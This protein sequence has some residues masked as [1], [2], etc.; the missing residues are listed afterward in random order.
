[1]PPT[2]AASSLPIRPT[3]ENIP[4]TKQKRDDL[5]H[6]VRDY[7]RPEKLVAPLTLDELKFHAAKIIA[8][9]AAD[10][11]YIDFAVILLNNEL[12]RPVVK[13][14]PYDKRLL[15]LPKC[16]RN[17]ITC[18][19]DLDEMGLI[20]RHCGQCVIDELKRYAEQLGYA[21]LIAEGSP[22]VLSLIQ[23]G[24]VQAIIG[25]SCTAVL[26]QT[27]PFMLSAAIPAVAIP[28][29]YD[30][31]RN[32][33][34][35]FD[36]LWDAVSMTSKTANAWLN[37]EELRKTVASWFTQTNLKKILGDLPSQAASLA[38]E[39]LA[40]A[41]KRYRPLLST[42]AYQALS[43]RHGHDAVK[44][45]MPVAVAVEC[46]HKASL[47]HDDIEDSDTLRYGQKTLHTEFGVPIALNVGDYLIGCGYHL[48]T[49]PDIP[50]QHKIKMLEIAAAAHLELCTGQGSELA[51][52]RNPEPL[53]VSEVLEILERKTS[54][55]FEAALT[56]AAVFAD[57]PE[58]LYAVLKQYSRA[59]GIA[60]Q[61]QD[62]I[63]DFASEVDADLMALR[64]SVL[65]ALAF[66][67]AGKDNKKFL[68]DCC[69]AVVSQQAAA[70]IRSIIMET[71]IEQAAWQLVHSYK[72]Q[73]LDALAAL[74]NAPLK[75]FLRTVIY[76]IFDDSNIMRCC[77][78]YK[79]RYVKDRQKSQ[80]PAG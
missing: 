13:A 46:F 69:C 40:T 80:K 20:C 59:L 23:T 47:I 24:K 75:G 63:N 49:L 25:A 68:R 35:D 28:L 11:G 7:L 10:P 29:L 55:A 50:E 48:L 34:L 64:P 39:S 2:S 21:V 79:A 32:T 12:W 44:H 36:Y 17:A 4:D 38:I 26:E 72:S 54:P 1:M 56:L 76:K 6:A 16:L 78:D 70:R 19:A 67:R 74:Q 8:Q 37:V 73:T 43:C 5:A 65:L 53:T 66:E 9:T 77:N 22:I 52:T 61:I 42:A 71:N 60:Y 15:L 57:A 18:P 30:G 41:G 31:C 33:T 14:I 45:F 27:F 58:H 3:Q 62:D 51:W